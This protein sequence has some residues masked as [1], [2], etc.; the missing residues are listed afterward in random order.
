MSKK[1][2]MEPN[3]KSAVAEAE[4]RLA[5]AID[6]LSGV[7]NEAAEASR[8]AV[9]IHKRVSA[10]D[11]TITVED[12]VRAAPEAERRAAIVPYY[13]QAVSSA[14][15]ALRLARTDALVDRIESG[16]V[17]LVTEKQLEDRLAPVV[18]ELADLFGNIEEEI[19]HAMSARS[20]VISSL[21]VTTAHGPSYMLPHGQ[22]DSPLQFHRSGSPDRF[23]VKGVEYPE[24]VPRG[25]V[26]VAV[27][28]ALDEVDRRR[29][30]A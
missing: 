15:R 14:E 1:E 19:E 11:T 17:G 16:A 22:P 25:V 5:D 30:T 20:E 28:L 6:Q 9:D 12:M 29:L 24:Y 8:A 27:E 2:P 18:S 21:A 4:A 26:K 10:G 13:R 3:S 7:E 23:E